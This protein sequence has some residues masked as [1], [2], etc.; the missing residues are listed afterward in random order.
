[1]S[2]VCMCP[3]YRYGY[4]TVLLEGHSI[5][6]SSPFSFSSSPPRP[7]QYAKHIEANV[8]TAPKK[9]PPKNIVSFS[10]I[11][12]HLEKSYLTLFSP[13]LYIHA[14][15]RYEYYDCIYSNRKE[16]FSRNPQLFSSSSSFGGWGSGC[17]RS[18]FTAVP[19]RSSPLH[20]SYRCM[21]R[22]SP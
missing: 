6:S 9:A 10:T 5:S 1:M 4:G 2:Y 12:I 17:Q 19:F 11:S 7:A 13:L 15:S 16:L 8:T 21:Y 18:T 20:I 14:E 3:L 22:A